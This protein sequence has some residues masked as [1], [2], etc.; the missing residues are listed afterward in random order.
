M[1]PAKA[2]AI[3]MWRRSLMSPLAR[4]NTAS[5]L[6]SED[7]DNQALVPASAAKL[8]MS[9]NNSR[10]PSASAD[11]EL[12]L[13]PGLPFCCEADADEED[14]EDYGNDHF[15]HQSRPKWFQQQQQ[16]ETYQ[17]P[18]LAMDATSETDDVPLAV[19]RTIRQNSIGGAMPLPLLSKDIQ[20]MGPSPVEIRHCVH[21]EED[22]EDDDEEDETGA[23][24][25]LANKQHNEFIR[26][27]RR[28]RH[29]HQQHRH[30]DQDKVPEPAL[31][32]VQRYSRWQK[33]QLSSEDETGTNRDSF[34]ALTN[35]PDMSRNS[36]PTF[37]ATNYNNNR[38]SYLNNL[39]NCAGR[40][41]DP[42]PING[43]YE[44]N[45]ESMSD[46]ALNQHHLRS[47]AEPNLPRPSSSPFM[48]TIEFGPGAGGVPRARQ[49][50]AAVQSKPAIPPVG[51]LKRPSLPAMDTATLQAA[52][53]A[54]K[55]M[56]QREKTT[57]FQ[58]YPLPLERN[59]TYN[60]LAHYGN[61]NNS[62]T[63]V[64][65]FA[66]LPIPSTPPTMSAPSMTPTGTPF[67][68]P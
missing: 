21:D 28:R 43:G 3:D 63:P 14:E 13:G 41:C 62:N 55:A 48:S 37:L 50:I 22:E 66:P 30:Q 31:L 35:T 16:R 17:Q 46:P 68:A 10:R 11:N 24:D 33:T 23:H 27:R 34:A 29:H 19:V 51:I 40:D 2:A 15:E 60:N 26:P 67:R 20:M 64:H 18:R 49:S 45:K 52:V 38:E 12:L 61:N 53:E 56:Q 47:S 39:N 58:S 44:A 57:S 59:M 6:H 1:E 9:R 36:Y 5:S 54:S 7:P 8:F 65:P 25:H 4:A 42:Y 32:R